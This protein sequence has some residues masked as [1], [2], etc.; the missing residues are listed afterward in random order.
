MKKQ[1]ISDRNKLDEMCEL[2]AD[3]ILS[4]NIISKENIINKAKVFFISWQKVNLNPKK[5]NNA[6]L[7]DANSFNLL[8]KFIETYFKQEFDNKKIDK[9]M[10]GFYKIQTTILKQST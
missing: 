1:F 5:I 10:E 4:D 2:L 6:I 7:E 9:L 8:K 3:N